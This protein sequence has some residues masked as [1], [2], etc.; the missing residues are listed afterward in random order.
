[1]FTLLRNN[2]N[3]RLLFIAQIISYLGDWFTF[4]ALAGLVQ[5]VT[6]SKLLVSMVLVA[7]SLPA[8]VMSPTAGS[9]ADRFDRRKILVTVSLAQG[10]FAI[11][12]LGAGPGRI[13]IVFVSQALISALAA[14]VNP[15]IGAAVPNLARD[16][17]ELKT[18]NAVFGS[19][20]GVML[21][22]GASLGG[23]FSAA[24]GRDAAFVADA[25]SF[26]V[27]A[28]LVLMVDAPMQR[29]KSTEQIAEQ[30]RRVRP[31]DDMKEALGHARRDP[32]LL[33]LMTS[34]ATFAIG[35]GVVSQLTVL[36]SDVFHGG[37]GARGL[38]LG[39][40]GVGAALGPILAAKYVGR[41]L[42]RIVLLCGVAGIAFAL[43]YL[44]AAWSPTLLVATVFVGVAHVGGGAN[45]TLST[46]GL[47]LR[48]DD[49]IL[50]R[51]L[52]GDF[53]L[54]TLI[55][56]I[57]SALA[58]VAS[59]QLGVRAAITVFAIAAGI[60]ATVYLFLTQRVRRSLQTTAAS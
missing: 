57:A 15:A 36:A 20:W 46:Y 4:V 53:A 1:M 35:T 16:A 30:S 60:A 42:S 40:R 22:V 54:F 23:A 11:T 24:F 52:A 10:V 28:G 41:N 47:Q 59:Q 17:A 51:I 19:S 27:A 9:F 3:L 18:A 44:G 21:A 55:L 14:F 13:W 34:K 31:I 26:V 37:D 43:C 6:G 48:A 8:F 25:V 38:V 12:L 56:A 50:G 45:W 39:A 49:A 2:R 32:V 33:A 58:G 5:D 29:A 7:L